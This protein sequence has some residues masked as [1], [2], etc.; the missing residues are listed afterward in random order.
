MMRAI[1]YSS[2]VL[3]LIFAMLAAF[4]LM[5]GGFTPY[6]P[7]PLPDP[8]SRAFIASMVSFLLFQGNAIVISVADKAKRLVLI[9]MSIVLLLAGVLSA[10]LMRAFLH[11]G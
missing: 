6:A 4:S 1:S 8:T 10:A 11:S 2:L 9:A 3:S 5:H 7:G